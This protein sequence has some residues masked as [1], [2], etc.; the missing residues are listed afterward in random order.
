MAKNNDH[1]KVYNIDKFARH[2]YCQGARLRQLRED[3]YRA[4]KKARNERKRSANLEDYED[5]E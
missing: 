2:Y 3:K 4:K 5:Y 1:K